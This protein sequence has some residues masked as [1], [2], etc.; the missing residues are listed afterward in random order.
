MQIQ[1]EKEKLEKMLESEDDPSHAETIQ[2]VIAYL[3]I[4]AKS[5]KGE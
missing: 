2:A 1:Q 4:I 3:P 5:I